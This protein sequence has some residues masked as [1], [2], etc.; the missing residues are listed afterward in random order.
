MFGSS[1]SERFLFGVSAGPASTC[2]RKWPLPDLSHEA[3][4]RASV[5]CRGR[6]LRSVPG[7]SRGAS[8]VSVV[9]ALN[10]PTRASGWGVLGGRGE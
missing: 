3:T 8:S 2:T 9:L 10:L 6:R 1:R 4:L 7:S 5:R